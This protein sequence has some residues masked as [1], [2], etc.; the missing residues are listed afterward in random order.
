MN[1]ALLVLTLNRHD[2]LYLICMIY[3]IFTFFTKFNTQY[4]TVQYVML[5]D[6]IIEPNNFTCAIFVSSNKHL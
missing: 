6:V 5:F 2:I 4:N 1:P 3:S